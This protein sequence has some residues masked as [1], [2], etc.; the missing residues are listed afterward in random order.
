MTRGRPPLAPTNSHASDSICIQPDC[1]IHSLPDL[2]EGYGAWTANNTHHN[3]RQAAEGLRVSGP[4]SVCLTGDT[5][6]VL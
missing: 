2:Q 6:N 3:L 1:K 4:T 5:Y